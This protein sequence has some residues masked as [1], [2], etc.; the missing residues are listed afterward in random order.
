MMSILYQIYKDTG[1]FVNGD[2]I[3]GKLKEMYDLDTLNDLVSGGGA[4]F[5]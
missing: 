4:R 3:W 2:E 5:L 1:R